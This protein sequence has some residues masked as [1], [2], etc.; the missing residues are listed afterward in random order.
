MAQKVFIDTS[1]WISYSLSRQPKHSTIKD[2]V[3]KLIKDGVIILT[4]NDVVD[5]TATRLIYDT[6]AKTAQKF[7]ELIKKGVTSNNLIQLWVDEEIQTEAFKI[8]EKFS[9]H[10]LSLT[11]ATTIALVKK[12][13]IASVISLDSDFAKVGISTLP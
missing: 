3:K 4:S 8:M 13:N 9:E 2:L 7:I 6:D 10:K 5:E 1:A 12:F 11:D